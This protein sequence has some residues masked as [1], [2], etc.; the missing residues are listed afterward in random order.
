LTTH[1]K[2]LDEEYL[3]K[4]LTYVVRL[5]TKKSIKVSVHSDYYVKLYNIEINGRYIKR[6]ATFEE[7]KKSI[8]SHIPP[9]WKD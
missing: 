4:L 5:N 2:P 1:T 9:L 8:V 6:G 3:L 7:A